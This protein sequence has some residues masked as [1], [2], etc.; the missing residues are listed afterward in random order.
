V[1]VEIIHFGLV[2]ETSGYHGY[3]FVGL[4]KFESTHW[5]SNRTVEGPPFS[6]KILRMNNCTFVPHR[7]IDLCHSSTKK[8]LQ[9]CSWAK[10]PPNQQ[11]YIHN[12]HSSHSPTIFTIIPN[13]ATM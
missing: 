2:S 7:R 4:K 13:V 1:P 8:K 9:C 11:K 5:K 3:T 10:L 12:N 6:Y